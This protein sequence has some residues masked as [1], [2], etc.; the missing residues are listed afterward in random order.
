MPKAVGDWSKVN[1]GGGRNLELDFTDSLAPGDAVA[2]LVGWTIGV[3]SGIDP[4]PT[5]RITAPPA[6]TGNKTQQ[7]FLSSASLAAPI[8]YWL[9]ADVLTT[10]GEPLELWS[11]I[12]V[13][14][15]AGCEDSNGP[16]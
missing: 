3:A 9:R 12:P 8:V 7:K 10:L 11:F 15:V 13:V 6:L 2:T 4:T 14:P 16:C 1:P 5:A